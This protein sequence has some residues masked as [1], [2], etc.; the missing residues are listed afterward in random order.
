[1]NVTGGQYRTVVPVMLLVA[2]LLLGCASRS[3]QS[4]GSSEQSVDQ[5][6]APPLATIR[7][8]GGLL[9]NDDKVNVYPTGVFTVEHL[10]GSR[11]GGIKRGALPRDVLQNLKA[12]LAATAGLQ[13]NYPHPPG[14]A[15]M[16]E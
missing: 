4:A 9:F 16:Y 10:S 6:E 5:S 12:N 15:D 14:S 13:E 7:R 3:S 8:S 1:M 11:G 2:A